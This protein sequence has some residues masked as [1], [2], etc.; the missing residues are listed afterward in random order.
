MKAAEESACAKP[1]TLFFSSCD[2][3]FEP[4]ARIFDHHRYVTEVLR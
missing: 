1:S 2:L 4:E 3:L